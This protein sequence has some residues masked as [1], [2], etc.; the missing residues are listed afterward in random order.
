MWLGWSVWLWV[1]AVAAL[2]IACVALSFGVKSG[3]QGR[4]GE[5]GRQ[6]PTGDQ[7]A[8]GSTGAT[9]AGFPGLLNVINVNTGNSPFTLTNDQ[10]GSLVVIDGSGAGG[11]LVNLPTTD[12]QIGTFFYFTVIRGNG[13]NDIGFDSGTGNTI[14][15]S[16][17]A[18]PG[19]AAITQVS[20]QFFMDLTTTVDQTFAL[21]LTETSPNLWR[22]FI[23]GPGSNS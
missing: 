11:A 7:G 1:V 20:Q 6:G 17:F 9:G 14:N 5:R 16:G 8:E 13:S 18:V 19:A 21:A 10:S 3:K 23:S 22:V 4:S 15:Y 2:V 12:A